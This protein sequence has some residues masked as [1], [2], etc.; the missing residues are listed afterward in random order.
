MSKVS[1]NVKFV[2]SKMNEPFMTRSPNYFNKPL[3]CP[4]VDWTKHVLDT[5]EVLVVLM[6]CFPNT[7]INS[8][9]LGDLNQPNGSIEYDFDQPIVFSTVC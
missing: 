4:F 5:I 7:K 1:L 8:A 3:T 9:T 6:F 2:T